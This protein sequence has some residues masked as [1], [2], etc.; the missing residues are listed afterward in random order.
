M[1]TSLSQS[2]RAAL[3]STAM[4]PDAFAL[5]RIDGVEHVNELFRFEVDIVAKEEKVDLTKLVGTHL[6]VEL[7]SAET[8][9]EFFDGVVTQA[10]WTG[11][12]DGHATCRVVLEPWFALLRHRKHHRIFHEKSVVDIL[13]EVFA[14]YAGLGN[15]SFSLKLTQSYDPLEYTVQYGESDLDF[16]RR[17]MERFG[18]S[19]YFDHSEQS[20]TLV[21]ADAASGFAAIPGG[22]RELVDV[23]DGTR[24]DKEQFS[25]WEQRLAGLLR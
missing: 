5:S 10:R 19:F 1:S 4:G 22:S 15:P 25:D 9:P 16:A 3:V 6:S 18:I 7:H 8:D 24:G 17:L 21:L 2:N 12:V 13:S 20:H 11:N 23:K 14:P